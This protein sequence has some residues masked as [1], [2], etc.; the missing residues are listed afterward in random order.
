MNKKDKPMTRNKKTELPSTPA[1]WTMAGEG[2]RIICPEFACD[3]CEGKDVPL[4]HFGRNVCGSI[5]I[6]HGCKHYIRACY[7]RE[8]ITDEML[9]QRLVD[10]CALCRPEPKLA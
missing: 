9:C 5:Q 1:E 10:P 8:V 6:S 3:E 7:P 4:Y 2:W